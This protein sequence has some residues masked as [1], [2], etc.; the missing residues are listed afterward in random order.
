M[1]IS[2]RAR[3]AARVLVA[4]GAASCTTDDAPTR[5][6]RRSASTQAVPARD[7]ASGPLRGS[8]LARDPQR[9]VPTLWAA[10]PAAPSAHRYVERGASP[11]VAAREQLKRA[12]HLYDAAPQALDAARLVRVHDTGRGPIAVVLRQSVGGV[13]VL[14]GDVKV[15]LRRDLELTAIGGSLHAGARTDRAAPTFALSAEEAVVRALR[16]VHGVAP[17]AAALR[18]AGSDAG[19]YRRFELGAGS[20]VELVRPARARS[21]LRKTGREL[22]PVYR[23]EVVS[24]LAGAPTATRGLVVDATSG[25]VV[26]ETDLTQHESFDYLVWAHADGTPRLPTADYMPH[27]AGAPDGSYPAFEAATVISQ[28]GFN[29]NPDGEVD[30]WLPD[31]AT[32]TRGNNVDAYTDGG[33][34]GFSDGD[35]RAAITG[36]SAF[37]HVFDT[38]LDPLSSD[39]QRMGAVTHLF[40][41]TNWLHDLWYDAGFVESAGNAQDDNFGRGGAEGDRMQAQAQDDAPN[42]LNNANMF[43]PADGASPVMQM[44]LFDGRAGAPYADADLDSDIVAHEFGHYLHHRLV[45]CEEWFGICHAES[46]GWGDFLSLHTGVREGDDLDG[47]FAMGVYATGAYP[48]GAYFGIRR[49]PYTRDLE[50]NGLTF[51]HIQDSSTLPD[52]PNNDLG[53]PPS[54]V[55]NAGEVWSAMMW[56]AYSNLLVEATGPDA[57]YDFAEGRGRMA[58]YVVAGM[59]LAPSMPDFTQQRDAILLA[60]RAVDEQDWLLLAQ[61]FAT[62]GAGTCAVSPP[63]DSWGNEGV[64]ES[65][66]VGTR[67]TVLGPYLF[68]EDEACDDDGVLDRGE[69]GRMEVSVRNDGWVTM[70]GAT[71]T[72]S[73]A[74]GRLTF[75]DGAVF[76]LPDVVP[77]DDAG[78]AFDVAL[79]DDVEG[80][81]DLEIEVTVDDAAGCEPQTVTT[82]VLPANYDEGASFIDPVEIEPSPWTISGSALWSIGE[83]ILGSSAWHG[84]DRDGASD[85]RL[86][87]PPMEILPFEDFTISFTHRYAFE[88]D[89]DGGVVE[90]STDGGD[91]WSDVSTFGE[92]AYD[93]SI[94]AI[95]RPAFTGRNPSFPDADEVSVN[96]G[97][98]LSGETVLV[99]FRAASDSS[100]GD[101]GWTVDDIGVTGVAEPPFLGYA[102]DAACGGEG[103]GAGGGGAGPTTTTGSAGEGG[104]T[105]ASTGAQGSTSAVAATAA[106][107]GAITAASG[108]G[109]GDDEPEASGDGCDCRTAPGGSDPS[110]GAL[111]AVGLALAFAARR[112]HATI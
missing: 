24:R 32:E 99:R 74:S 109:G 64:V 91:S 67:A 53:Y 35:V 6:A 41:T 66:T 54:E 101:E 15:L 27:P 86:V 97:S 59:T 87:S 14:H 34:D 12:L 40:Y 76:E 4:L 19:D 107:S 29:T 25:R 69:V 83:G 38:S 79:T 20:T 95:E 22:A 50:R 62:R 90:I 26:E 48:E 110:G 36:P 98:E 93:G 42:Q 96:L 2:R 88:A 71:V 72:L 13:D 104:A 92:I 51:R 68:E 9:G 11:E 55:H 5:P 103:G 80:L 102:D 7:D 84:E 73:E 49:F 57:R 105:A 61:G 82:L 37:A 75:L 89:Y 33:A 10:S 100:V 63:Q 47:T 16:H 112:R 21:Y 77:G 111:V 31:D 43:T 81:V 78:F 85:G 28:E 108:A 52:G 106:S 3:F 46:E 94:F 23:V 56:Q 44:Y 17:D 1:T 70:S 60:A 65:F 8:V 39:A 18:D 30:P 58:E 45:D